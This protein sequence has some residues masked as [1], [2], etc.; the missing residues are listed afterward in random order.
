MRCLT[1]L[2][3][4]S[5]V[6]LAAACGDSEENVSKGGGGSATTGTQASTT[7][8][9]GEDCSKVEAPKARSEGDEKKPT[10]QL[11]AKK[12]W[13]AVMKTNC[14]TLEIRL[15]VRENPKTA[16]SFAALARSD[17]YDGLTFHRIVPGFVVQGGDPTGTGEG[18]PGYSVVEA[19]PED[20]KYTQGVVAMAKTELE[21]PGT[22]G[23]QFFIVT[24]DDAGLPAD[25]A[26]VGKVSKGLDVLE[27]LGNVPNDPSDNKPTEPVVI[28]DVSV[29]E[30]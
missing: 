13:T 25:Y 14:G 1:T 28:E 27:R 11:D 16:S 30:G 5:L 21:K 24:A 20:A 4:A 23:S 7:A 18:G 22:S 15:D 9:A 29:R 26:I 17:F 3:L 10:T 12:T 19:P 8:A 2:L 6:A